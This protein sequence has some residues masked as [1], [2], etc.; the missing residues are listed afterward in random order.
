MTDVRGQS[1]EISDEKIKT[2]TG[3]TWKEWFEILDAADAMKLPHKQIASWL[4]DNHL[5]RGWW[6]QSITVAYEKARGLRVLGQTAD[7]G[8][9]LGTQKTF[10][11][12][13]SEL[14]D[15]LFSRQGLRIWLGETTDFKL[16]EKTPYTTDNGTYGEVRTLDPGK[17]LRMTW[18]PA[19]WDEPSTLQLYLTPT[20]TGTSLGFHQEKLADQE[21][22][23]HMLKHW[24]AVLRKIEK[25]ISI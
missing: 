10:S 22:R 12:A 19:D 18:Q 24:K 7:T 2:T 14:W 6:C 23:A 15:F 3:R 11:L 16:D 17:R 25:Q 4:Y 21:A 20:K 1:G 5:H 13:P 8:F 9:Q